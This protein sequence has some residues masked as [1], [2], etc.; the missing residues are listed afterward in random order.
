MLDEKPFRNFNF[1]LHPP[2]RRN[3]H[4]PRPPRAGASAAERAAAGGRQRQRR[5]SGGVG[6]RGG[7]R[8]NFRAGQSS[9]GPGG[10]Q[11]FP[12]VRTAARRWSVR[13][14]T[15]RQCRHVSRAPRPCRARSPRPFYG[16]ARVSAA[17]YYFRL[18][19]RGSE[20][21]T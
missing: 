1:P 13:G 2:L 16:G 19:T 5:R 18:Y 8:R 20:I 12:T 11:N 9:C 3:T 17:T 6:C 10:V 4:R 21:S 15:A 14:V 7:G